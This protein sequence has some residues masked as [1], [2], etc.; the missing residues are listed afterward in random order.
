MSWE[1]NVLVKKLGV[2]LISLVVSMSGMNVAQAATADSR[3]DG[4]RT[5]WF[6]LYQDAGFNGRIQAYWQCGEY[7]LQYWDEASSWK[8]PQKDGAWVEVWSYPP[9]D[10]AYLWS[11]NEGAQNSNVGARVN[12]K[13]DYVINHC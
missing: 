9:S 10:P 8:S 11:M 4:I 1:G 12:D 6:C 5:G 7:N 2:L 13:A 3:C